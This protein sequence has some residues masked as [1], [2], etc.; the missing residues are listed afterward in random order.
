MP[1]NKAC[2]SQDPILDQQD[3]DVLFGPI[4]DII[5]CHDAFYLELSSKI[6]KWAED[7]IIG[8]CI[9]SP[10]SVCSSNRSEIC[11]LLQNA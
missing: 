5:S 1:L 9:S 11:V 10:V 2:Q 4:E 3:V 8:D 6:E 7:H